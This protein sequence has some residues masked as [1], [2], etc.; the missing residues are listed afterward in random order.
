MMA[1]DYDHD[2]FIVIW[3]VTRMCA[4][5]CK[6][7]RAAAQLHP[8]PG[9]L[10]TEEGKQ[11]ID[12]IY[13][14]NNP[15]L[16]FSG[17]DPLMRSDIFELIAYAASK[18]MRVSMT[19]SATPRLTKEAVRR[20][21]EAG[22]VRWAL[23]LDGPDAAS[24]DDFRGVP[25][26]FDRTMK[27]ASYLSE[28][29]VSLQM[30]T[31]VTPYN[32]QRLPEMA[33]LM[34]ACGVSVWTLFFL[35]PTGR[36]SALRPISPKQHEDVL[37]WAFDLQEQVPYTVTTTEAQFFRRVV[38][39]ENQ[40]RKQ[41]GLKPL[42]RNHDDLASAPRGTNDGNG[43]VFISHTGDVQPSG[44]L[45]IKCGNVKMT[46]LED[47]YRN[48]FVFKTLRDPDSTKGKCGVCEYRHICG[49]SRARAYAVTGDYKAPEPY[50]VYM[51]PAFR[52]VR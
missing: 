35:V 18:G 33:E 47:I 15:L 2:P 26:I 52:A 7:C 30:N 25:G 16:V 31:T 5:H 29:G 45:P 44:F 20:S 48:H 19:P 34:K 24:H 11:L 9:E 42:G 49:G 3:E 43:F 6:H 38:F 21:K 13:A 27:A 46:R 22:I 36:G 17:G 1:R 41:L 10:T 28:Y 37:R 51:P 12:Q 8:Y 50:C 14:M 23:S 39:Q 32:V 40:R 4:F